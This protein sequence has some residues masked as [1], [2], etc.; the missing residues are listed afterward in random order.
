[1]TRISKKFVGIVIGNVVPASFTWLNPKDG[2]K[3]RNGITL[4]S[5]VKIDHGIQPITSGSFLFD[6]L[7]IVDAAISHHGHG[8]ASYSIAEE[9]FRLTTTPGIHELTIDVID[10]QG[11]SYSNTIDIEIEATTPGPGPRTPSSL[12]VTIT[13]PTPGEITRNGRTITCGCTVTGG[14]PPYNYEWSYN[15]TA[16]SNDEHPDLDINDTYGRHNISVEVTDSAGETGTDNSSID[17]EPIQLIIDDPNHTTLPLTDGEDLTLNAREDNPMDRL[18]P[19]NWFYKGRQ[20]ATGRNATV[21]IDAS[22]DT[23]TNTI[24]A[25]GTDVN[26]NDVD[27]TANF[28]VSRTPGP[29]PPPP[30]PPPPPESKPNPVITSPTFREPTKNGRVIHCTCIVTGGTPPYTYEWLYDGN[31]FSTH[32][33]PDLPI[34]DAHGEHT[35]ELI[36]TDSLGEKGDTSAKIVIE[37]IEIE[38]KEP[39]IFTTEK[40]FGDT[41]NLEAE[42]KTSDTL[43][44]WEWFCNGTKIHDGRSGRVN[45]DTKFN[46]GTNIIKVT[47]KDSFGIVSEADTTVEVKR[48]APPPPPEE[49]LQISIDHPNNGDIFYNGDTVECRRTITGGVP[50]FKETWRCNGNLIT[51]PK[52]FEIRHEPDDYTIELIVED[53]TGISKVAKKIIHVKIPEI[54]II[55]PTSTIDPEMGDEILLLAGVKG[56]GTLIDWLWQKSGSNIASGEKVEDFELKSPFHPGKNAL[57]V[58]ARDPAGK[59]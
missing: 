40:D 14:T 8:L 53:S 58:I 10:T 34:R 12:P 29:V 9:T 18:Y 20:V 50:P 1:M 44:D 23:G 36:V 11:Y 49:E 31:R 21:T 16:F 13:S 5:E 30:P 24:R 17:I 27:A 48:A 41:L 43:T 7:K 22:F 56:K 33:D 57:T 39:G 59:C 19:I 25:V 26:G 52:H 51:D 4:T 38:I 46:E 54:E 45:V 42:P 28:E 55:S 15:G 35:V 32:E 6:G 37:P 47:A 2:A 3:L